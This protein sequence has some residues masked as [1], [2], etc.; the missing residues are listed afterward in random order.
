MGK[1]V[2]WFSAYTRTFELGML[3]VLGHHK[4]DDCK[5]FAT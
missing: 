1:V 5:V 4:P 2:L 3:M